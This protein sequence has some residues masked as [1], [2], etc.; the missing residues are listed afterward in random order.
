MQI[1]GNAKVKF[2]GLK[3][4]LRHPHSEDPNWQE[5]VVMHWYDAAN[6][7]G[8]LH[9]IGHEPNCDGGVAVL[10][11][12]VFSRDGW[13]YKRDLTLPLTTADRPAEGFGAGSQLRFTCNPVPTWSVDDGPLTL[14][15]ECRDFCPPI[16]TSS[17]FARNLADGHFEAAGSLPGA[18]ATK[19][20]S[21][22]SRATGG[23]IT[24]GALVTGKGSC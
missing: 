10:W 16:D 13:R 12:M 5:S 15:L 3:D 18:C 20:A 19:G 23:V 2:F 21:S 7:I 6:G 9:R 17:T 14:E 22:P 24:A 11:S 4:E 8:G 1:T